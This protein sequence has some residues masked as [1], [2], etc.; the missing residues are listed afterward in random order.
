MEYS[1]FDA[2]CDTILKVYT[3]NENL[4]DCPFDINIKKLLEFKKASQVF[5]IFNE[6]NLLSND[7]INIIHLLKSNM[8]DCKVKTNTK[9][10]EKTNAFISIEGVGN[11]KDLSAIDIERFYNEGVRIISLTWNQNNRLCGGILNNNEGLT[12]QG[13]K[14]L[15]K[16][17][18]LNI[19]LD[20]SHISDEG[21]YDCFENFDGKIVATHSNSRTICPHMRNLTDDQFMCIKKRGGV[22]GMNLYPLFINNSDTAY[23][24]DIIKHIEYFL[25]LG[26]ENNIGI[27]AD[28]D[29][30][31]YKM[32][33]IS[34]VSKMYILFDEMKKLNYSDEII[35][36]ISHKN[37]ENLLKNV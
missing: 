23:T 15:K 13:K 26:G 9:S 22:V 14:I 27:G 10:L 8:K 19:I 6:G 35:D 16:M 12:L 32:K 31:E 7:I 1:L 20:V 33:D 21:F 2:H 36:K 11:T 4:Y 24:K 25:S 28:F 37:F 5:A 3:E 18:E 17:S 30:I 29:G 34:D